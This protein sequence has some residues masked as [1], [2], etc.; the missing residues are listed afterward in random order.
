MFLTFIE[1]EKKSVPGWVSIEAAVI[2]WL[3]QFV[4]GSFIHIA[5]WSRAG[6]YSKNILSNFNSYFYKVHTIY[7]LQNQH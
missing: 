3:N 1:K 5:I 4:I 6:Q 2:R 7:L